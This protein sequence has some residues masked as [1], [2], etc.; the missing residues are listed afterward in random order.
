MPAT[1]FAANPVAGNPVCRSQSNFNGTKFWTALYSVPMS[2]PG[3][4]VMG[5]LT[6]LPVSFPCC[7]PDCSVTR[8][9]GGS[10][11]GNRGRGG[12]GYIAFSRCN[13]FPGPREA[14]WRRSVPSSCFKDGYVRRFRSLC[15]ALPPGG[16]Q[17]AVGTRSCMG[18][19]LFGLCVILI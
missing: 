11:G 6:S 9:K 17:L 3:G 5:T 16:R 18:Y 2:G 1:R 19:S 7:C 10:L 13:T 8:G 12:A 14:A 4:G 15:G